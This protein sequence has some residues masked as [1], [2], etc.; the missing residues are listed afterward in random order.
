MHLRV[1][2]PSLVFRNFGLQIVAGVKIVRGDFVKVAIFRKFT[3]FVTIE[4]HVETG[5]NP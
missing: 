4:F 1:V 3:C 5:V 2:E